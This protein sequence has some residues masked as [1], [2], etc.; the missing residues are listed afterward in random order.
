MPPL[1][2]ARRIPSIKRFEQVWSVLIQDTFSFVSDGQA[3]L[4]SFGDDVNGDVRA[5]RLC[6]RALIKHFEYSKSA[7]HQSLADEW[8][9]LVNIS[10]GIIVSQRSR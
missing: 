1:S 3:D 7:S 9:A 2:E 8:L 5:G 10:G 6:C 4:F